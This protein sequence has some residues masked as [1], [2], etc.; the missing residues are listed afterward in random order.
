MFEKEYILE[1][2]KIKSLETRTS[3]VKTESL[4]LG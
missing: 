3:Q 2:D 1:V 4:A